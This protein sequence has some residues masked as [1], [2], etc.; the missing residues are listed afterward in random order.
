VTQC[1]SPTEIATRGRSFMEASVLLSAVKLRLFDALEADHHDRH[2]EPG[3]DVLSIG[4]RTV[5]D[6][7]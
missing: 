7:V 3:R 4:A 2:A 6:R 5:G 1:L